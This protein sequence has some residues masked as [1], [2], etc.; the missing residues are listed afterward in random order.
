[1]ICS[2]AA[3]ED[4]LPMKLSS[5]NS[6]FHSPLRAMN[7]KYGIPPRCC[8]PLIP[9]QPLYLLPVDIKKKIIKYCLL[10]LII[11]ETQQLK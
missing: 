1:M 2:L 8:S 9:P 7:T 6:T 4:I 5:D 10:S 11:Q 3:L